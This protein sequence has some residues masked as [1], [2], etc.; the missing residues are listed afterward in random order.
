MLRRLL[1]VVATAGAVLAAAPLAAVAE[2]S[3]D[4]YPTDRACAA[5]TTGACRTNLEWRTGTYGPAGSTIL[6]RTIFSVYLTAGEVLAMGSS[7]VGVGSGDVLVYNPGVVTDDETPALPTVVPG[8]N[9]FTCSAQRTQSGVAAQGRISS[10]TLEQAGPRAAAGGGNPAGYVPCTYTAATTGIYKAVFF[11][12]AGGTANTDGGPT[13]DIAL[14]GA[15]NFNA[16]QGT[17]IA[18][19]DLTVRANATSTT[20]IAGRVFTYALT[21]FTGGNGRPVDQ[22]VYSTSTDGYQYRV[23]TNGLDPNGF[24]LYGNEKGFLAPDGVTPLNHDVL[25]SNGQL[26][27]VQGGVSLAAPEY[28]LSFEPLSAATLAALGIGAP[29]KPQITGLSFTGS[30]GDNN[31]RVGHGGTFALTQNVHGT[32]SIVISRDGTNFDPG[33]P[34]NRVLTGVTD[35]GT[36][37]IAWDGLDNDG[38]PFPVGTNYAVQ[39]ELQ[40]GVNH[41]PLI[42]AENSVRGGPSFTLLNPPGGVCP[43]A[44]PPARRRSMTTAATTPPRAGPAAPTSEL[45]GRCCAGTWPQP[46]PQQPR[47]RLRQHRRPAQVGRGDRR[48]HQHLL[49]R[50]LRRREGAGHL[51]VLPEQPA[52]LRAQHPAAAARTASHGRHER[53]PGQRGVHRPGRRRPARQRHRHWHHHHRQHRPG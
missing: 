7:A 52:H 21:A 1:A 17:S 34:L 24:V 51:D 16:A 31:S 45:R 39:A 49:H 38:H 29:V 48:Q 3:R 23:D 9:G 25:G 13:G 20:D 10:R 35:A 4:L 8:T 42:D 12:P 22:V 14:A 6:R 33:N 27:T 26:A 19:W 43:S 5:T 41:F 15:G 50:Q 11:G 37:S 32:Y 46:R 53:H 40:A 30:V 47:H 2:G 44:T 18:A 36:Q 28:P